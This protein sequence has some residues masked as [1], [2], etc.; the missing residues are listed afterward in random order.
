MRTEQ[1][2]LAEAAQNAEGAESDRLVLA[3]LEK[4]DEKGSS[5]KLYDRSVGTA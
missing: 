1:E 2:G 3:D 4:I 5:E